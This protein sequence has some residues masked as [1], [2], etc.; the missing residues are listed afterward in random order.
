MGFLGE[1]GKGFL[2]G[3]VRGEEREGEAIAEGEHE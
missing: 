3:E 2:D 1:K